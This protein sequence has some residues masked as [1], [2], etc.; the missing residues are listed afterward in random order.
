MAARLSAPDSSSSWGCLNDLLKIHYD[1]LK[2]V[3]T[4]K[5]HIIKTSSLPASPHL[6]N[7]E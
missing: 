2:R 4:D 3:C 1:A 6:C 5:N 7:K